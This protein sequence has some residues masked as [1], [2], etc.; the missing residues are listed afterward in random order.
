MVARAWD[1]VLHKES[2]NCQKRL[3]ITKE[4]GT[5]E[6][7]ITGRLVAKEVFVT[8]CTKGLNL[9]FA[10]ISPSVRISNR[11]A[12]GCPVFIGRRTHVRSSQ[13]ILRSFAYSLTSG[14]CPRSGRSQLGGGVSSPIA[15]ADT[16]LPCRARYPTLHR[17][18]ARA[19]ASVGIGR[20]LLA[21]SHRAAV[22]Y[23]LNASIAGT[24]LPHW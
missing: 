10:S 18:G 13:R 14:A 7:R 8:L 17:A 6:L 11:T 3:R 5:Y 19:A 2:L 22:S 15:S 4:T 21:H 23:T 16:Y 9:V 12:W 20:R 24:H 1:V